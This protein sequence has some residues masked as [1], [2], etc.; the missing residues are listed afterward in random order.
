MTQEN[1]LRF[2]PAY[3]LMRLPLILSKFLPIMALIAV[4]FTVSR[5]MKTRELVAMLSSGVSIP[6]TLLLIFIVVLLM[7]VGMYYN[8]A[9][10]IPHLGKYITTSEKIL[11]SEGS[12]RFLVRQT[13][14][15]DFIIKNYNYLKQ[16]MNDI[17]IDQ[18]DSDRNLVAQIVAQQGVWT[19]ENH[20]SSDLE[21]NSNSEIPENRNSSRL[22]GNPNSQIPGWL[23][24]NGLIY[25]YDTNGFRKSL[26]QS[27][28][29]D[30]FLLSCELT[31]QAIEKVEESSA[32]MTPAKLRSL[33]SAQPHNSALLV[34]YYS[35]F[36]APLIMLI[37]IFI[38]LPFALVQKSTNFFTGIG[39]CLIISL[40]FF[41]A[42]FLCESLG[43]KGIIPPYWAVVL[44]LAIFAVLGLIL[45]S[46]IRT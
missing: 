31:P 25:S 46:R 26:P 5:L 4:M 42:K 23:L 9:L 37:L 35:R 34:Q 27:F 29:E 3:Y 40:G 39:V 15:Y 12:E 22:E 6:R 8:D 2:I 43:N 24:S 30:G 14:N 32:Y 33:I 18:Y 45:S 28:Q 41:A 11:K 16:Q 20:R 44:P 13:N 7:T 36:T 19:A 38:G 17:W 21:W 1:P 10:I